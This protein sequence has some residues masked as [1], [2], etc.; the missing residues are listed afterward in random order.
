M[1]F[2]NSIPMNLCQTEMSVVSSSFVL[3]AN[4]TNEREKVQYPMEV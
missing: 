1:A 2:M 3:L 4:T